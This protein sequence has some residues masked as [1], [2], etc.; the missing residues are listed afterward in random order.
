MRRYPDNRYQS[1]DELL[2]DLRRL[3]QIDPSAYDMS[4]E[5]PMGGLGVAGGGLFSKMFKR[6]GGGG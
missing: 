4:P 2:G 1:A 5:K 6:R 3:D